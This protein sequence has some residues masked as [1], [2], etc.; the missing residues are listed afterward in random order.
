MRRVP[1]NIFCPIKQ[2]WRVREK[3]KKK[4]FLTSTQLTEQRGLCSYPGVFSL[5]HSV[6]NESLQ[7]DK[8]LRR[9]KA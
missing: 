4:F 7:N 9:C 8:A 2:V 1:K 5:S 6:I 3:L